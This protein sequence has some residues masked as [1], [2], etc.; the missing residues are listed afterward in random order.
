MGS[1]NLRARREESRARDKLSWRQ[2]KRG[3]A[4]T[5]RNPIP[6]TT[7]PADRLA[8]IQQTQRRRR[9]RDTKH[10]Q[11]EDTMTD[12]YIPVVLIA[13][14]LGEDPTHLAARLGGAVI[15]DNIGMKVISRECAATLFAEHQA[16]QAHAAAVERERAE[17]HR[18]H[19]AAMPDYAARVA[20][21]AARQ[22]EMRA[23]GQLD[24]SDTLTAIG[25]AAEVNEREEGLF[26]AKG[27][28]TADLMA[29]RSTG[30]RF[31]IRHDE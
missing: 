6:T 1:K 15:A 31:Q 29:G 9:T 13:L 4:S 16:A 24:P 19:M 12:P 30:R 22:A 8:A 17:A 20:A 5:G 28:L 11:G 18:Q 21:I 23:A 14:E 26:D 27:D 25:L 10:N 3:A 7:T 2:T